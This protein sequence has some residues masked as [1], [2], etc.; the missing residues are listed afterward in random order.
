MAWPHSPP[1][2]LARAS[3][4]GSRTTACR[5]PVSST[6]SPSCWIHGAK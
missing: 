2:S 4:Q 3:D 1:P 5:S 6:R